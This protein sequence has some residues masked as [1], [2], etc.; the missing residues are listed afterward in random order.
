LNSS[1]SSATSST[2]HLHT[3]PISAPA[4]YIYTDPATHKQYQVR[5]I[6]ETIYADGTSTFVQLGTGNDPTNTTRFDALLQTLPLAQNGGTSHYVF[7]PVSRQ[8]SLETSL[9]KFDVVAKP[10]VYQA[11]EQHFVTNKAPFNKTPIAK[12][13]LEAIVSG[14][15]TTSSSAP[16]A[17]RAANSAPTTNKRSPSGKVIRAKQFNLSICQAD[18][19]QRA[20]TSWEWTE[21]KKNS[22][23]ETAKTVLDEAFVLGLGLLQNTNQS[24]D[25]IA[26]INEDVADSKP[27]PFGFSTVTENFQQGGIRPLSDLNL[28]DTPLK[29]PVV[30]PLL[31]PGHFIGLVIEPPVHPNRRGKIIFYDSLGK[32]LKA[33][34]QKQ[35]LR[36]FW[37]KNRAV[38][39]D[40][41]NADG[42]SD[43]YQLEI[44]HSADP[45]Q[46]AP[47]QANEKIHCGAWFTR[48][49]EDY[50]LE[51]ESI[52]KKQKA[53]LVVESDITKYRN[54]LAR[55]LLQKRSAQAASSDSSRS[56]PTR[57]QASTRTQ[58]TGGSASSSSPSSSSSS[59]SSSS[60]S[61]SRR[62]RTTA[63]PKTPKSA[64]IDPTG[65]GKNETVYSSDDDSDDKF[66]DALS[67]PPSQADLT[68]L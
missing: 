49:V 48:F 57:R 32:G 55:D 18:D 39:G 40:P 56:I 30:I 58:P 24:F 67:T 8:A 13:T 45:N 37:L 63:R 26:D 64:P 6:E 60:F 23:D 12:N 21:T 25:L 66:F 61:S 7:D 68:A 3:N 22:P 51:R 53:R 9:N 28:G 42:N 14:Q 10:E 27:K 1:A 16:S 11:F 65:N 19:L 31:R 20:A 46:I 38:L 4:G 29:K 17:S 62:P 52:L 44:R 50:I 59:S 35:E 47:D 41:R 2:T 43:T 33:P 5:F 34:E 15:Q 36:M 54:D